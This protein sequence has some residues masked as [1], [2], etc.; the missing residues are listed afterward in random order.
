MR[1]ARSE[2][3]IATLPTPA[4]ASLPRAS[5]FHSRSLRA[6]ILGRFAPSGFALRACY[7]P[8]DIPKVPR[9]VNAKFHDDRIKTMGARGIQIYIHR[10]IDSPSV[11]VALS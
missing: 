11:T 1:F 5:R 9:S 6:C 2:R 3:R 4:V 7:L 8:H 10:D